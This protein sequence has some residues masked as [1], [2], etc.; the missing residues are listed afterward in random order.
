[1]S[2]KALNVKMSIIEPLPFEEMEKINKAMKDLGWKCI[3]VDN[4]NFVFE[5]VV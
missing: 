3:I 1:M 2:G 4:G 5:K